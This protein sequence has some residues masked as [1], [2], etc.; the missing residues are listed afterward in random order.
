MNVEPTI[1][2]MHHIREIAKSAGIYHAIF[3]GFGSMLG[4]VR[5]DNLLAHDDDTDMCVLSELI[6]KEQEDA[7]VQGLED[8]RMF[9]YRRKVERR[10]DN[11][12]LLWLSLKSSNKHGHGIYPGCAKSCIWFFFK[13]KGFYFHSKG[14]AWIKKLGPRLKIPQDHEAIGKGVDERLFRHMIKR[15]FCGKE[16]MFPALYGTIL[17]R[18]YG[19]WKVPRGGSS[20]EEMVIIVKKWKDQSTWKLLRRG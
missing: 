10:T 2:Q 3:P 9:E 14:R 19:D 18:W 16:Y 13:W 5:E 4:M 17:D 7:F 12:R 6:T 20:R 11:D 1:Q 15:K 8:A